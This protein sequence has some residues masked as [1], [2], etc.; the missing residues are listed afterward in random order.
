MTI[1]NDTFTGTDGTDITAHTSD[2]GGTWTKNSA[3]TAGASAV[4]ATN[5]IRA[6]HTSDNIY[7]H[8][9]TPASADYDVEA[10]YVVQTLVSGN[11]VGLNGR[12]ST[13]TKNGYTLTLDTTGTRVALYKNVSGTATVLATWTP[14]PA[15]TNGQTL[16]FKL[17]MRGTT[18]NGYVDGTL[19]VTATDSSIASVGKAG[20]WMQG[21]L[22]NTTG[23]HVDNWTVSNAPTSTL[24]ASPT[25]IYKG[26]TGNAIS[27]SSTGTSWTSG[28]PGS[29][30]FTLTGGTGAAKTAQTVASATSATLTVDAGTATG[31]LTIT[32]PSTSNTALIAV[33]NPTMTCSPTTLNVST[34]G[35]SV[36]LTGTGT[37]WT[38]GTP[39]SPTFTISG[40]T[41]PA[42]TAQTVA[43]GTSATL[44]ISTGTSSGTLTI[45]D[46][47]SGATATI[48]VQDPTGGMNANDTFTDLDGVDLSAH[49]ADDGQGWT[50]HTGASTSG[51]SIV[52]GTN[53]IHA[54][55]GGDNVYYHNVTPASSDYV[56]E[57]DFVVQT[58]TTGNLTGLIARYDTAAKTGYFFGYDP[59]QTAWRLISNVAGVV[60]TLS[61]TGA[62]L[63]AGNT[64]HVKLAVA[65][66]SIKGYV[67]GVQTASVTDSSVSAAGKPGVWTQ[68]VMSSTTG[69]NIDNFTA[70]DGSIVA[71][72]GSI[73]VGTTGNVITLTGF[74]TAWLSTNPSFSLTG[75]T[76]AAKTAQNI[77][78]NTTATI[79][80]SAGSA[81]ATLTITDPSTG[82]NTTI[83]VAGASTSIPITDSN[84]FWSPGNWDRTNTGY[85]Q[86]TCCGAYLKIAFTGTANLSLNLDFSPLSGAGVTTANYPKL[87]WYIDDGPIQ[88][89]QPSASPLVLASGLSTGSTHTLRIWMKATKQTTDRWTT[90]VNVT[91]WTGFNVDL[92]GVAVSLVGTSLEPRAKKAIFY[93]DSITEGVESLNVNN[94][95]L[96]SNDSYINFVRPIA[97]ALNAEYGQVGYGF[98]GW[99]HTANGNVPGL[100]TSF[101]FQ[102]NGVARNCS[103]FDYVFIHHGHND[104]AANGAQLQASDVTT[105]LTSMRAAFGSATRIFVCVPWSQNNQAVIASAVATQ[106]QTDPLVYLVDLGLT[107]A[108]GL[109]GPSGTATFAAIDGIHPNQSASQSLATGVIQQVQSFLGGF[110][111]VGGGGGGGHRSIGLGI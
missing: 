104:T 47:N 94:G 36:T 39:G 9:V 22:T 56:V 82:A 59:A 27:L 99:I 15:I 7:H 44:T 101:N 105:T 48:T 70:T 87:S 33:I 14:S 108:R 67:A 58:I 32:D 66:T 98:G 53:R 79:T 37:T 63:T 84:L 13:G 110:T 26:T 90:P 97:F 12:F 76:G 45:T 40:G 31:N 16:H 85:A 19:R 74:G 86:T 77:T 89:S 73:T 71:S 88:T 30:T 91:R 42:I 103:G 96:T 2:D 80:V 102:S 81:P 34:T 18:I 6:N 17:E 3:S 65:G 92:G 52:V 23:V 50:K 4:I 69:I 75:G 35:N 20:L 100:K 54:N 5:R 24:N 83:A 1:A 25:Q 95:D 93:G 29:P 62:T 111:S 106:R 43:S 8:S 72:P 11:L 64:Y 68:G 55:H 109:Q 10:D 78:S 21:A 28:T 57:A 61:T 46:P 107:G 60:T 51:A 49:T 41:G 38:A